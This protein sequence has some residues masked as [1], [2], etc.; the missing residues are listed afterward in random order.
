MSISLSLSPYYG[1]KVVVISLTIL[2]LSRDNY[3]LIQSY[4]YDNDSIWVCSILLMIFPTLMKLVISEQ[5]ISVNISMEF[6]VKQCEDCHRAFFNLFL[7]HL[8][9]KLMHLSRIRQIDANFYSSS[10]DKHK[11]SQRIWTLIELTFSIVP[12]RF[13]KETIRG[14]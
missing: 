6:H 8:L 3:I 2:V 4:I 12:N 9:R 13:W 5:F 11:I 1:K 7:E 10:E 14:A